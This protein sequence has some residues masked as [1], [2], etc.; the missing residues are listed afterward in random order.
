VWKK[1][2]ETVEL[3]KKAV[4]SG[5]GQVVTSCTIHACVQDHTAAAAGR[6]IF[7]SRGCI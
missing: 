7:A 4:E 3:R 6:Y 5:V 1:K 2:R